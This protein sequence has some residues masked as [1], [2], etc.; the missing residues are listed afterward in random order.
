MM[1]EHGKSDRSVIPAKSSNKA[2]QPA[3]EGMEGRDLCSNAS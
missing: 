3:A 2:G 1:N